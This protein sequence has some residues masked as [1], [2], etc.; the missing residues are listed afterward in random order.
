MKEL[1][2]RVIYDHDPAFFMATFLCLP[3]GKAV[4]YYLF[5]WMSQGKFVEHQGF[6]LLRGLLIGFNVVLDNDAFNSHGIYFFD[7]PP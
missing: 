1:P 7:S 3:R 4:R 5:M 2:L 6:Y